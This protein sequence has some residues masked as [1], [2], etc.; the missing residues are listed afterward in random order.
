MAEFPSK[1]STRTSSP[2]QG[3]G[4]SVSA[5][6][7]DLGFVRSILGVLMLLQL[8]SARAQGLGGPV[9]AAGTRER[10]HLFA[11]GATPAR[12]PRTD[13]QC[14]LPGRLQDR[15]PVS[16]WNPL[17][18]GRLRGYACEQVHGA[19]K[20]RVLTPQRPAAPPQVVPTATPERPR[21]LRSPRTTLSL[22]C[23]LSSS[24]PPLCQDN[25]HSPPGDPG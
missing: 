16:P 6:R 9:P 24:L 17:A 21:K 7:P 2:A 3:A 23:L 10:R 11:P 20:F 14:L 8:V 5:L 25:A 13:A 19:P 18:A 22:R 12:L 4:A 15:S 1:V